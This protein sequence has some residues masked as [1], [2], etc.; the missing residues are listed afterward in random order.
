MT[1]RKSF[2]SKSS[3]AT[4]ELP[5]RR[6]G[7]LGAGLSGLQ[8]AKILSQIGGQE[9]TIL[10]GRDRLGGRAFSGT[11]A[12]HTVEIGAELI[13]E[14][15]TQMQALCT[16][17]NIQLND[18][19]ESGE[20][21][22]K[23]SFFIDGTHI[24]RK[25]FAVALTPFVEKLSRD[26]TIMNSGSSEGLALHSRLA[27]TSAADYFRE[28]ALPEWVIRTMEAHFGGEFGPAATSSCLLFIEHMEYHT[29]EGGNVHFG[30]AGYGRYTVTEGVSALIDA[31]A[32]RLQ[33]P[34]RPTH[35]KVIF[36]MEHRVTAIRQIESGW[37]VES[38][39][40]GE[41]IFDYFDYIL[42][43]IPFPVLRKIDLTAA[44]LSEERVEAI[45][46]VQFCRNGKIMRV[47]KDSVN[48]EPQ[49]SS[50][51]SSDFLGTGATDSWLRTRNDGPLGHGEQVRVHFLP[52]V[53]CALKV[54]SSREELLEASRHEW[55]IQFKGGDHSGPAMLATWHD[56]P[57][58][59]GAY[60]SWLPGQMEE[61][62]QGLRTRVDND[63]SGFYTAGESHDK[64]FNGYMEG[65]VRQGIKASH[66]ILQAILEES[67]VPFKLAA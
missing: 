29:L 36:K 57:F 49:T 10:E 23:L 34:L 13:D 14:S 6:I 58:A 60:A 52:D 45:N 4:L 32:Q 42:V 18:H 1:I 64:E 12:G 19:Y 5:L 26:R 39:H 35:Q 33:H 40:R 17:F 38:N 56:D 67:A 66:Q 41:Q 37:E 31:I 51:F 54:T 63:P 28:V 11:L 3:T 9:V 53:E 16:E 46:T 50:T 27:K 20:R 2:T 24:S 21:H 30:G 25:D 8:A 65:A 59:L 55:D 44:H 62:D 48:P 43:T 7:I 22:S 47:V 15:H 61:I